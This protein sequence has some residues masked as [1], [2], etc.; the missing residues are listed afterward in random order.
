[1]LLS[2][3]H[4]HERRDRPGA[5]RR[6]H[7]GWL[8][9]GGYTFNERGGGARRAVERNSAKHQ[10]KLW[11]SKQL[12]GSLHRWTV[13]GN[14]HAQSRITTVGDC[15]FTVPFCTAFDFAQDSY[16]VI[17]LRAAYRA[18]PHWEVALS[19]NNVLDKV[20]YETGAPSSP[21]S[22]YGEPRNFMVRLDG[23]Y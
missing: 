16:A 7:A 1:M 19:V 21:H 4:Q 13:G 17:D 20:Y 14:L 11:T 6:N 18:G 22:W 23:R 12:P 2:P 15:G 3:R 9:G 8:I 5:Q 10:L